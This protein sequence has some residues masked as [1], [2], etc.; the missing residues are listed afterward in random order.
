MT[1]S[2][3]PKHY[4]PG[5]PQKVA[6][7]GLGV[8]GYPMA[9]HLA[10]AGLLTDLPPF[11]VGVGADGVERGER[12]RKGKRAALPLGALHPQPAAHQLDQPL[13]VLPGAGAAMCAAPNVA[14]IMSG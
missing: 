14:R 5:S 9:G 8:M 3:Q 11:D 12:Q 6:F 10:R 2:I 7:I 13:P 1:P 4:E